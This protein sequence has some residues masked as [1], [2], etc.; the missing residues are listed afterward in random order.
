MRDAMTDVSS[1]SSRSS[2]SK[3]EEKP[4]MNFN[5]NFNFNLLVWFA[6]VLAVVVAVVVAWCSSTCFVGL[7]RDTLQ[8]SETAHSTVKDT[9]GIARL[10][11]SQTAKEA[12]HQSSSFLSR[13][14]SDQSATR[15]QF[16][17]DPIH[18]STSTCW[19]AARGI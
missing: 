9:M 1:H 6:L 10:S 13:S 4:Q 11:E 15:C 16:Q 2:S 12:P 5:F 19:H 3:G 8:H 14:P 7:C 18:H 17:S